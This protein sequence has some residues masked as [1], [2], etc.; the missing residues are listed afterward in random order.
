VGVPLALTGK[1]APS[2]ATYKNIEWS[3]VYA[4]TAGASLSGNV[5]NASAVG[6]VV[7]RATVKNGMYEG[8][9]YTQDFAILFS[10]PLHAKPP[11]ITAQPQDATR[12]VS[13]T[14]THT[15]T[16]SAY[17]QDGGTLSYQWY[18]NTSPSADGSTPVGGNSPSYDAPKNQ[19]GFYYYHVV[20]TNTNNSATGTKTATT[21]SG[22]VVLIIIANGSSVPIEDA[23]G[24]AA[25]KDNLSGDYIL[26]N[27]IDLNGISWT[28]IGDNIN[29]FTGTFDGNG[30]VI[31][32]MT[33]NNPSS[34]YQGLFAYV[35]TTGTVK[36]LGVTGN[37]SG[38]TNVGGIVGYNRGTVE[39]CYFSGNVT[40]GNY[41][42]GIAGQARDS[43]SIIRN[44]YTTGSVSTTGTNYVGGIVGN[45]YGGSIEYC[46]STCSVTG[47]NSVGGISGYLYD[48][49]SLT[50]CVALNPSISS[51]STA[52][53]RVYGSKL[54]VGI[55]IS[56]NKARKD[57][58]LN[59]STVSST[60]IT[61]TNGADVLTDNTVSLQTSVFSGWNTTIW[62]I[63]NINLVVNGALPT[64]KTVNATQNPTLPAVP[65]TFSISSA[66]QLGMIKNNLN[67][68]YKLTA[69]IDMSGVTWTPLGTSETDAFTGTFDGNGHAIENLTTNSSAGLFIYIGKTALITNVNM[70]NV[71]V[72]NNNGAAGGIVQDNKGGT[73]QYC[74]VSGKV[75]STS[76]NNKSSAGGITA[77]NSKD[78]IIQYCFSTAD[79]SGYESVGGIAGGNWSLVRNCYSTGKVTS[80]IYHAGGVVGYNDGTYG[81]VTVENCY[82]TG[83]MNFNT[84]SYGSASSGGIAWNQSS[85]SITRNCVALCKTITVKD[86][87]YGRVVGGTNGTTRQNNYARADM[88]VNGSLV[89]GGLDNNANG[90]DI[91]DIQWNSADWWL[92][93]ALFN[94]AVWDIAYG[95]LPTLKGFPTTVTQNPTVAP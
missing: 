87:D 85:S 79:V 91:T 52:Y 57:M 83:E 18:V 78:G 68:N 32:N 5:L 77:S 2:F 60:D 95:R 4:E 53:G 14:G 40:G 37:V 19:T 29:R 10:P 12:A 59:G 65:T 70:V 21:T 8:S 24:L 88:L 56:N 22:F 34:N 30:H 90:A 13:A 28:T 16:V 55:T 50:N 89:T 45:N 84:N 58:V 54:S 48:N 1:V 92:Y 49:S 76:D 51:T 74:S 42:G 7:V 46:Y 43:S 35:D 72:T 15:L 31:S 20:V 82:A 27:D 63:P 36:N 39:N 6:T 71:S 81:S 47:I 62:N 67:G 61:S 75:Q 17:S 38:N 80:K 44:C 11:V 69:D 64:L 3:L 41:V 9:D 73:I 25:I 94:T 66:A 33:I 93:T 86:G 23:T 26:M